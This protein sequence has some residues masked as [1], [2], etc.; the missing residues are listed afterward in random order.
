MGYKLDTSA[1]EKEYGYSPA[2]TTKSEWYKLQEGSNRIRILSPLA[3]VVKHYIEGG[4][5]GNCLGKD[6][7]CPGCI[8]DDEVKK[9]KEQDPEG[10]KKLSISRNIRWLCHV[11]DYRATERMEADPKLYEEEVKLAEFPHRIAKLLEEFQ[12]DP[13]W[14]F[15]SLPMPY[16]IKINVEGAGKTSVKYSLVGSPKPSPV[17][18]KYLDII[19]KSKTPSE[20]V[21]ILKKK[22][23]EKLFG[24]AEQPTS[25]TKAFDDLPDGTEEE[26][27]DAE[28][29]P[30]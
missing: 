28:N 12:N 19:A 4:Y 14:T 18:Q 9:L 29:I 25:G 21:E 16:D 27:I 24:V 2:Q 15:D 17:P 11:L 6:D 20:I 22:D 10:N 23:R 3:V 1:V 26:R 7:G 30:F 13:D 5:K 8:R